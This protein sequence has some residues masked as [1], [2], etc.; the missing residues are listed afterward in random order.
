MNFETAHKRTALH[1]G[2]FTDNPKDPGNWTSGKCGVGAC[3]GTK[4]GVAANSYPDLD[5]KN[6]TEDDCRAIYKRDY[7]APIHGDEL[8]SQVAF[9]VYD[10]AVN[11]GVSRAI[12]FLQ[13][14]AGVAA[15]GKIGSNTLAAVK[16]MNPMDLVLKFN[17][18]RLD[19]YV[20]LSTFKTF[21]GG[22]VR[23]VAQNLRYAAEDN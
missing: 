3:K 5:I 4:F 17:A 1:E 11:H 23:R 8:P 2:G 9:S 10:S 21:G 16:A 18:V 14:A 15:D 7:W 20:S 19:F 6:L 22:W 13:M 12:K